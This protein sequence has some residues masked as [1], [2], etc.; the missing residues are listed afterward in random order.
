MSID[1]NTPVFPNNIVK[2]LSPR[3]QAI[4]AD[5]TVLNRPLR[6]TDPNF[7]VGVFSTEWVPDEQSFEM[8]NEPQTPTLGNYYVG[9][10]T[11]VKSPDTDL[12]LF[13]S[14]IFIHNVRM[15]LYRDSVLRGQLTSL[16]TTDMWGTES[17]RRYGTQRTGYISNE[18][19]GTFLSVSSM[20]L[21]FETEMR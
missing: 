19:D 10:Q 17:L 14:G 5:F 1:P 11:L 18:I 16:V 15:M 13:A 2:T 9:I 3:I 21:F 8:G 7:S 4:D 12:G 6:P 20:D